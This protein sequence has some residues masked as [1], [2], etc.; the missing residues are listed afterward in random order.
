MAYGLSVAACFQNKQ[1]EHMKIA[2]S[3][4]EVIGINKEKL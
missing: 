1:Y 2:V 3:Q 4:K